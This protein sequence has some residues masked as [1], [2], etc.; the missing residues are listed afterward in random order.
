[1]YYLYMYDIYIVQGGAF[2][3]EIWSRIKMKEGI[4]KYEN[5]N[6]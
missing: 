3:T 6:K 1:M 2:D 5:D 4:Q